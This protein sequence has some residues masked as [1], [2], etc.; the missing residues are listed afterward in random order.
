MVLL[1][2]YPRLH[3]VTY[4]DSGMTVENHLS[5]TVLVHVIVYLYNYF[6]RFCLRV[7][8]KDLLICFNFV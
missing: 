2:L 4:V 3:D 5:K 6:L 8:E 1:Q 7:F